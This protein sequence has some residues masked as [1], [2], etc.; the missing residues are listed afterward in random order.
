MIDVTALGKYQTGLFISTFNKLS[1]LTYVLVVR[2]S[3][4]YL[5]IYEVSMMS[6][7]A[8]DSVLQK[9]K[10]TIHYQSGGVDAHGTTRSPTDH[11]D[12]GME[13]SVSNSAPWD[14]E[15]TRHSVLARFLVV[16]MSWRGLYRRIMLSKHKMV[17]RII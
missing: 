16:K 8:V 13:A 15:S 4:T 5:Y 11:G 2:H 6:G 14:D 1:T 3:L 17:V 10:N 9:L 7:N 12:G